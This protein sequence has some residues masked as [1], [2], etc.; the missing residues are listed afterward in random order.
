[1]VQKVQEKLEQAAA[2]TSLPQEGT[3]CDLL[4]PV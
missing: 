3:A 4:D 1:M 2:R